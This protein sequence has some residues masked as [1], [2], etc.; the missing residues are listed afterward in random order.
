MFYSL[1]DLVDLIFSF[2]HAKQNEVIYKNT[3]T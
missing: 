2:F 1:S 3:I